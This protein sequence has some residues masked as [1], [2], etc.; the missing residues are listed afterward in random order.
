MMLLHM[1]K[2]FRESTISVESSASI[3][4]K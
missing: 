4:W 3:K 1:N 2:T